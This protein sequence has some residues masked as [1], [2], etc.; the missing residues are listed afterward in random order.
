M[1]VTEKKLRVRDSVKPKSLI[2]PLRIPPEPLTVDTTT[3]VRM[4][5]PLTLLDI[6]H[7]YAS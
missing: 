1:I 4:V 5:S 7:E 6:Q 2:P 3:S